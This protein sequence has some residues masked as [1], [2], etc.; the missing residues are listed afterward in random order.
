M[1]AKTIFFGVLKK[2]KTNIA[3]R[4]KSFAV[5]SL[6]FLSI[7]FVNFNY[8]RLLKIWAYPFKTYWL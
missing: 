8:R 5:F 1:A 3:G 2:S 7:L 6:R 4:V